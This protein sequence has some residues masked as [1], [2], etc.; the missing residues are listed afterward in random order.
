M[1]LIFLN[2]HALFDVVGKC[3]ERVG[4]GGADGGHYN[5]Y[6]SRERILELLTEWYYRTHMAINV[7]RCYDIS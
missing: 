1:V 5:Y 4:R 2:I 7:G 6:T 3:K